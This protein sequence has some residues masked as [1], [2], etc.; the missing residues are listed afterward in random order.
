MKIMLA[1]VANLR[2]EAEERA[3]PCIRRLMVTK[4]DEQGDTT[5]PSFGKGVNAAM[6]ELR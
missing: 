5:S 6:S 2:N 3:L 1:Q 4:M